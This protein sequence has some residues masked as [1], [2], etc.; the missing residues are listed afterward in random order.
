MNQRSHLY[1]ILLV[2]GLL[3]GACSSTKNLP[4]PNR[5]GVKV[6]N[7]GSSVNSEHDD[8]APVLSK[9]SQHLIFTSN[10][11]H[12]DGSRRGDEFYEAERQRNGS[13]TNASNITSLNTEL[14][15]GGAYVNAEGT[16]MFFVICKA[17]DGFGD[18]DIYS[19]V[20]D[21][22]R[23]S[24]IRNLGK[25]INT[26]YWESMPYLSPGGDELFFVS[27]RPG[28]LGGTD[29]YVAKLLRNGTWGEPKNLGPDINTSDDEK[30][31]LISPNGEMLYFSS[32]GRGGAGGFDIFVAKR[33]KNKWTSVQNIGTPINSR[34][35]ELYFVLTPQEDS[36]YFS[37]T[38]SGGLGKYDVWVAD[39]NPYRDTMRYNYYVAARAVDSVTMRT[40]NTAKFTIV[41]KSTMEE[42]KLTAGPGGQAKYKTI[43]G[44]SYSV[45]ITADGYRDAAAEF[46]VPEKLSYSEYRK[47]FALFPKITEKPETTAVP[48]IVFFEFDKWDLRDDALPVLDRA[49][50]QTK[51]YSAFEI[52]LDAHTD[53]KGTEQ[54]N[55]DLSRKRGAIVSKYFTAHG[56]AAEAI[57]TT[58]HGETKPADTNDTDEGRAHN[59]RVEIRIQGKKTSQP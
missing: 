28:G 55:I 11:P 46:T 39:M 26:K 15:E 4:V 54:Y 10:R 43:P 8:Y 13:W 50:I 31:P 19:A 2:L 23:W 14:D 57:T 5:D 7:A 32:N 37:S 51:K 9:H 3:I 36:I 41:N 6:I 33:V 30:S 35:D 53:E 42:F 25:G 20:N 12:S 27:D 48:F 40:I 52:N 34:G 45:R 59:R 29:I 38:R 44:T 18:G 21:S 16:I 17:D 47:N 1:S 22:G 49:L 24:R 58:P 56:V